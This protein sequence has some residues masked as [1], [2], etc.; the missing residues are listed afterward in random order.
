M[1]LQDRGAGWESVCLDM[2]LRPP[3]KRVALVWAHGQEVLR[4]G[5]LQHPEL[6]ETPNHC[7]E[8][9]GAVTALWVQLAGCHVV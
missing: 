5:W 9:F 2:L 6:Q 1:G 3:G 8:S 7:K 4:H